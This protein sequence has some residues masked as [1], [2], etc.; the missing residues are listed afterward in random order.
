[1]K[2]HKSN[3]CGGNYRDWLEVNL[4]PNCNGKCS[5]CIDKDSYKPKEKA[6]WEQMAESIMSTKKKNVVLLGG[7]PTLYKDMVN[8]TSALNFNNLN[9]YVTTNGSM[10]TPEYINSNLHRIKG[11]NISIHDYDMDRNN[12]I[13]G[14]GVV[15]LKESIKALH[16]NNIEVRLNCNCIKGYIDSQKKI[17]E[18]VKFAK[19]VGADS[20]RFAE[21][22]NETENFIDLAKIFNHRYGLNDNPFVKGCCHE[23]VINK[24]KVSFRQMCGFQTTMR[25]KP[26]NVEDN[27]ELKQVLYYD[28]KLY[29]GW[30]QKKEENKLITK[31][32]LK[33]IIDNIASGKVSTTSALESLYKE[34]KMANSKE[35]EYTKRLS[36][37]LESALMND[38]DKEE[39]DK[40]PFYKSL[41][42]SN[43]SCQY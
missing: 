29:D 30:K 9:V 17:R 18:Y 22:K 5:W 31:N 12:I 4:T 21:L 34:I 43:T 7:E 23:A 3:W 11:I 19:E 8:L 42:T 28:G 20:V 13:T 25:K 16:E 2:S 15:D 39:E 41:P 40:D 14:V 24:M 35:E 38:N 1:V 32:E 6:T 37:A 26:V 33:K 10:L 36:I 27:N